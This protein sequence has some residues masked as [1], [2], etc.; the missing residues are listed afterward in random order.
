M[1]EDYPRTLLELENRFATDESCWEY[2]RALRWPE[3]FVCPR[4]G[5]NKSWK[6]VRS[7]LLCSTCR[8]QTSVTA[9]TIFQDTRL[10]LV[11]WFRA[12]WHVTNEKNGVSALS[13]QR[14]LGL[15][16]YKTAWF[17]LH[18]LRRAMVRPDRDKLKGTIEVDEAYWGGKEEGVVGRLTED[19]ALIFIAVEEKI[20]GKRTIVGRCRLFKIPNTLRTTLHQAITDTIEPGSTVRT[21]GLSSYLELKGYVQERQIQTHQPVGEYVLP[22]AHLVISLFKRW[23]MG[24]HQGSAGHKYLDDYLNEFTFRFNRRKSKSRG[25]LFYRLVQQAVALAPAP[26]ASI[27]TPHVGGG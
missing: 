16:S 20:E 26:C 23:L 24:T 2:L 17:L 7:L 8:R 14:A 12:M 11:L 21:D 5:G 27:T 10:P 1:D 18:K 4:C 19:K 3:G 25:K 22:R 9:G 15:G 6:M 13:L